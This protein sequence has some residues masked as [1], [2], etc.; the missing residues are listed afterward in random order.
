MATLSLAVTLLPEDDVTSSLL[1][2]FSY[3][4]A[5]LFE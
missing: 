5:R 1:P 4:V 2:G 3:P